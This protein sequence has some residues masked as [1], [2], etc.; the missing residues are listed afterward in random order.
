MFVVPE[1]KA[2]DFQHFTDFAWAREAKGVG[3]A[4]KGSEAL[5]GKCEQWPSNGLSARYTPFWPLRRL[6]PKI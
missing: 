5:S 6:V 2:G 4:E 1:P 3:D